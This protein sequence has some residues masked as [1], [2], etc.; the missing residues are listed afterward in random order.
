M[1]YHSENSQRKA[2]EYHKNNQEKLD[3][4]AENRHTNPLEIN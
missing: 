3:E 1:N 2:K 4:K